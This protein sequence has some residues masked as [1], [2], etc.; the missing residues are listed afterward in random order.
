LDGMY[1]GEYNGKEGCHPPDLDAVLQRA[2][3]AGAPPRLQPLPARLPHCLAA[4][5]P[6]ALRPAWLDGCMCAV[7]HYSRR[8]CPDPCP[9]AGIER[10]II[11]AGNLAEARRA[12][13]LAR[14]HGALTCLLAGAYLQGRVCAAGVAAQLVMCLQAGGLVGG[15]LSNAQHAAPGHPPC[16]AP[17]QHCG[18]APHAVRRV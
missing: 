16:R 18:G 13:A 17:V 7:F 3:D 11:T 15:W 9:A 14:T 2:F 5:L 12:L 8:P 6:A 10:L 4:W 1:G